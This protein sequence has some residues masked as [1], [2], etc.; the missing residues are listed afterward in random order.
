MVEEFAG[1]SKRRLA[2]MECKPYRSSYSAMHRIRLCPIG[3]MGD[4]F[5]SRG[6]L[7]SNLVNRGGQTTVILGRVGFRVTEDSPGRRSGVDLRPQ[8]PD[9]RWLPCFVPKAVVG[10]A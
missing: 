2:W 5:T 3:K 9:G 7:F 6:V 8:S 1:E 10:V 4:V